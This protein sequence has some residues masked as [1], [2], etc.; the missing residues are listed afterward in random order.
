MINWDVHFLHIWYVP[1]LCHLYLSHFFANCITPIT[2]FLTTT[3]CG[4]QDC[5]EKVEGGTVSFD[6]IPP[7]ADGQKYRAYLLLSDS[8]APYEILAMSEPFAIGGQGTEGSSESTETFT[9]GEK[10]KGN[11]HMEGE[12]YKGVVTGLSGNDITIQYDDD[13][14]SETLPIS[15]VRAVGGDE[16]TY[17]PTYEPTQEGG[18]DESPAE[19][20][21]TKAPTASPTEE[22]TLTVSYTHLTLPTKA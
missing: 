13:G 18:V 8:G 15:A 9:V 20:N 10:V 21:G 17:E 4:D 1:I 22:G 3:A 14:T 7:S 19:T 6:S 2:T 11:W 16:P 5:Y 12:Y